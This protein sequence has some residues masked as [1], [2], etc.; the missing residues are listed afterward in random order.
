[1]NKKVKWFE[2]TSDKLYDRHQ[3]KLEFD[4]GRFI[5]MDSYEELRRVWFQY[6]SNAI[7]SKGMIVTVIDKKKEVKGFM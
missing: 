5:T 3:Y 2:Q 7:T 4:D 1:M 6:C